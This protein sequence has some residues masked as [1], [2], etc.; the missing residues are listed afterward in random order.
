MNS[1]YLF[2]QFQK[3]RGVDKNLIAKMPEKEFL[4]IME[5]YYENSDP[6]SAF[7]AYQV[8]MDAHPEG[9]SDTVAFQTRLSD[10]VK[11]IK[12]I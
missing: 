9:L 10:Y 11:S 8:W 12:P 5:I 1:I 2:E 4:E 3:K 6:N 7:N